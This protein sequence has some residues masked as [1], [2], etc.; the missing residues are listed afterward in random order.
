[1]A[2]ATP[3]VR[4]KILHYCQHGKEETLIVESAE[5]YRWLD[6]VSVFAFKS[7]HGS[8]TARKEQ[9]SNRRGGWYW[10]AYRKRGGILYRAYLGKSEELTLATMHAIAS[11]LAAPGD[12]E[13]IPGSEV[14]HTDHRSTQQAEALAT[15]LRERR[16]ISNLPIELTSFIGR[17]QE[18]AA[19]S[20]LLRRDNIR[21]LTLTGP[22]GVGKTRLALQIASH[23]E[24]EFA[25]G[26]CFVSFA[27]ISE[28]ELV[29]PTIAQAL[30]IK[31]VGA[32]PLLARLQDYLREKRLLLLLDNFEQVVNAASILP[33]L[34]TTCSHLKMMVTSRAVLH[35][36]G[37]HQFPL[38][39]LPLPDTALDPG[40]TT[41]VHNQ[42]IALFYL[43]AQE[44]TPDFQ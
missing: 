36:R 1:M 27:P 37:E 8:F 29:I 40:D 12:A 28:T 32:Q 26:A 39:P 18:I 35:A 10:K 22:G 31:E 24:Q 21:L 38:S 19:A 7:P 4:D 14:Q 42:A 33:E 11:Q 9:A 2:R 34:L 44:V 25:D 5:W 17:E 43:R 30:G 6:T 3:V 20:T 16:H 23:L 41:L 13:T 15:P